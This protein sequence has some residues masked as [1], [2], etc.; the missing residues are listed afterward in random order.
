MPAG[1][2]E[3]SLAIARDHPAF[4]GHFPGR[5]VL[6]GVV[7]LAEALAGIEATTGNPP[8]AWTISIVKFL[9]PVDPGTPLTLALEPLAS[10]AMR[11]E[12]RSP[13]GV[14]ASGTCSLR[15]AP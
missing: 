2:V 4:E 14:V 6:P 13:Q 5:P 8:H 1:A 3:T 9:L 10:G 7:L 12:I 15:E 11:F